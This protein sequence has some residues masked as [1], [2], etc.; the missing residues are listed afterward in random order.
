MPPVF[1][2]AQTTGVSSALLA[3]MGIPLLAVLAGAALAL[4]AARLCGWVGAAFAAATGAIL[5]VTGLSGDLISHAAQDARREET[6]AAMAGRPGAAVIAQLQ[7][8]EAAEEGNRW[9]VVAAA[10]EGLLV[11]GLA[12][13][14]ILLWRRDHGRGAT[15]ATHALPRDT[16]W[17]AA[18][19]A[20]ARQAPPKH[21]ALASPARPH[22]GAAMP[23]RARTYPRWMTD[24]TRSNS[25]RK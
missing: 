13:A 19:P 8:L 17:P 21:L 4:V 16:R 7:E 12:S 14:C 24:P 20:S 23:R 18:E 3:T 2:H 6:L 10:G 9:H 15:G 1:L 22:D 11:I 5:L 25:W